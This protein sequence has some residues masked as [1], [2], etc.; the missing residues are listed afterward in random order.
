MLISTGWE[1]LFEGVLDKEDHK[2]VG[3]QIDHHIIVSHSISHHMP[4]VHEKIGEPSQQEN[5]Q[6]IKRTRH[7]YHDRETTCIRDTKGVQR[8]WPGL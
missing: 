8:S 2:L 5:P 1:I 4:F 3:H 6:D 7:A